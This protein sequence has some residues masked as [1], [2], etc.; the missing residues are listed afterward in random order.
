MS[1]RKKVLRGEGLLHFFEMHGRWGDTI[2]RQKRNGET[3]EYD[4]VYIPPSGESPL[5]LRTQVINSFANKVSNPQYQGYS[6]I[7]KKL[8]YYTPYF[9]TPGNYQLL[10][11]T[12]FYIRETDI[13]TLTLSGQ[14][15]FSWQQKLF[16][17]TKVNLSFNVAG[18]Y[19]IAVNKGQDIDEYCRRRF[20]VLEDGADLKTA[21]RDYLNEYLAEILQKDEP[22]F[23]RIKTYKRGLVPKT[24]IVSGISRTYRGQIF[25]QRRNSKITFLRANYDHSLNAQTQI[26][27]QQKA[28]A[29][30]SWNA[31]TEEFKHNWE[32]KFNTWYSINYRRINRM[33]TPYMWYVRRFLEDN[34]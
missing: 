10:A 4:Y 34:K 17:R 32:R 33:M 5:K 30:I 3:E 21:Y 20:I 23:E 22:A 6:S 2:Y 25:Y 27:K 7:L 24:N 31:E 16:K 8:Y 14:A 26:F 28:A 11:K 15:G 1:S 18:E 13:Y 12:I 19:E 9:I 29:I